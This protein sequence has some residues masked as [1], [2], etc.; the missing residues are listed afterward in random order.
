MHVGEKNVR[1][2][3]T[4]WHTGQCTG[5]MAMAKMS[6][7]KIL[8]ID[9]YRDTDPQAHSHTFERIRMVGYTISS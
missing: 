7:Y 2:G 4:N 5:C 1:N 6:E 9:M 8:H 3:T